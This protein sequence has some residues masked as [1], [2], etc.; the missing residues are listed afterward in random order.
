[1]LFGSS[2][3][4]LSIL[5]YGFGLGGPYKYIETEHCVCKNS[6]T[7]NK[8]Q[9]CVRGNCDIDLE[10]AHCKGY[11]RLF[12]WLE[13]I[14][15]VYYCFNPNTTSEIERYQYQE[16]VVKRIFTFSGRS[17]NILLSENIRQYIFGDLFHPQIVVKLNDIP[18]VA[19][20]NL[21]LSLHE[22]YFVDAPYE[23][24]Y[25]PNYSTFESSL[26]SVSCNILATAPIMISD[27]NND[28]I[29]T[30]HHI[31]ITYNTKIE[32]NNNS[33]IIRI[34]IKKQHTKLDVVSS[35]I[36]GPTTAAALYEAR[37]EYYTTVLLLIILGLLIIYVVCR[38]IGNI[39][40][41]FISD[42]SITPDE[43]NSESSSSN[44]ELIVE[45]Q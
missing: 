44:T 27:V 17:I 11:Y 41:D 32:F 16:N 37:V 36:F 35:T 8:T 28:T 29:T 3:L 14:N 9:I 22:I 15:I 26:N 30:L 6:Q 7:N 12:T 25:Q 21:I 42:D 1:M 10:T 45:I 23:F 19:T 24:V 33:Q 2:S 18:L 39:V 20:S 43:S 34:S 38:E 31:T 5:F 40:I 13:P 4:L